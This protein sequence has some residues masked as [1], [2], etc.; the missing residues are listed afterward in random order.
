M[1]E[2]PLEPLRVRFRKRAGVE[3]QELA[4]A[5]ARGDMP[6][7]ERLAHGLAGV[8]GLFGYADIGALALEIDGDFARGEAPPTD[9]VQAL[10]AALKRLNAYS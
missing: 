4:D 10:I 8:A 9:T 2:D 7:V 1:S 5:L 3:S 6:T